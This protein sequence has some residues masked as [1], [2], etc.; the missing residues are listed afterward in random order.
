MNNES[1]IFQEL[2]AGTPLA[3]EYVIE[4]AL[5]SGS[6]SM[7]YKA[8][9]A[10]RE[11]YYAIKEFFINGYC[12]RNVQHNTVQ[13][14]EMQT[15][16][17]DKY[18]Q[19]FWD[20]AQMMAKLN[21]PNIVKV[22]DIFED[23][24]T[25]YTVM[26]FVQGE[27]L[28]N[29]VDREKKLPYE[30]GVNYIAQVCEALNYIHLHDILHHDVKPGNIM[31][32][33]EEK[34]ILMDFGAAR[35]FVHDDMQIHTTALTQGYAPLEQYSKLS[36]KGAYTD[37]YALGAVFYFIVTGQKP[38]EAT[39][40]IEQ[41]LENPINF[42]PDLPDHISQL[43]LKAMA[44]KP[45]NRYQN[46]GELMYEL[47]ESDYWIQSVTVERKSVP[48][49]MMTGII[50]AVAVLILAGAGIWYFLHNKSQKT[51][52]EIRETTNSEN[53]NEKRAM[54]NGTVENMSVCLYD[55]KIY[56]RPTNENSKLDPTFWYVPDDSAFIADSLDPETDEPL[57]LDALLTTIATLPD[58]LEQLFQ[59]DSVPPGCAYYRYS[60]QM[61]AG[62][63]DDDAGEAIY[64][65]GE[66]KFSYK[67]IFRKGLKE[68][69]GVCTYSDGEGFKD[70]TFS[71]VYKDDKPV[72]GTL[73]YKDA[74]NNE[75]M[76]DGTWKNETLYNGTIKKNGT[77]IIKYENGKR[78]K[79]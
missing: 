31:I 45:E 67:G 64:D 20:E 7:T 17:Y 79:L 72:R 33:P 58:N 4:K 63:P 8:R 26:P 68:G 52:I 5:G 48:K 10:T 23:N 12:T 74:D 18:K 2:P 27:T 75:Y 61:V 35:K 32:T 53:D 44:L 76:E 56:L 78:I 51:N 70:M 49:K 16:L 65:C 21:H 41:E 9:H 59:K 60:G 28:Q 36:R 30:T 57:P 66:D 6:F 54:L 47:T 43:I 13:L 3:Q 71:G 69:E 55:G 39:E 14:H 77:P 34:V 19:Q 73:K 40:R 24:G 15:D 50:V 37:V 22:L 38:M 25:F 46:V 11:Q 42:V 1:I 62:Y 29:I